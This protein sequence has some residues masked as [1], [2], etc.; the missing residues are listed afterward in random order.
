MLYAQNITAK[1]IFVSFFVRIPELI[2][3]FEQKINVQQ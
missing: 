3:H 2:L 1:D